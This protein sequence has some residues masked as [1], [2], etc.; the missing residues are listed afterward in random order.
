MARHARHILLEQ[1]PETGT[2]RFLTGLN[3]QLAEGKTRTTVTVTRAGEF[4]DPRYGQF[5][6]TREMLLSMVENFNKRVYG[7]DIF[8]DVAHR[9]ENG[10]AGKILS[11]SV[12]GNRLRAEVEWTPYGIEAI[13]KKGYS[14]LSAEY[15]ENWRD[16]EQG[17]Q[18]GPVLLG[19]AL[20][21]RPVIKRL[22]PV[23]LSED[24]CSPRA[25]G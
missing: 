7:Q 2:I 17:L 1:H 10:A 22:D 5:S 20:T 14:Y 25:W 23:R 6:I 24:P 13:R 19:A 11:L 12:E 15:H 9:P 21:V 8:I 18:H 4:S 16:N 3:V